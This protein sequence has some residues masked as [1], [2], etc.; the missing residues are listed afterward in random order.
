MN[1][2]VL[3]REVKT[4]PCMDAVENIE[5]GFIFIAGPTCSGKTTLAYTLK[6][7]Y[8][9][10]DIGVTVISQEDYY[11]DWK[12]IPWSYKGYLTDVRD[13]FY[14]DEFVRDFK[15][16][17]KDGKA[18][19]PLF[20]MQVHKRISKQYI[21][22]TPITIVEGLHVI[23]TFYGMVDALYLY[24]DVPI[25]RCAELRA[26]RDQKF[27]RMKR[28][29]SIFHFIECIEPFYDDQVFPQKDYEGVLIFTPGS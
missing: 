15:K 6:G 12:N 9:Q 22:R 24:M 27:E 16:Y 13:A 8:E 18:D 26:N 19:I 14:M 5:S 7:F 23:S 11:K 1:S 29:D 4:D 28:D 25:K 3:E 2:I 20:D 17:L 10:K 21:K